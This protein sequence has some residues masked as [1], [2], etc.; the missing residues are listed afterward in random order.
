MP[1]HDSKEFPKHVN[2]SST[3]SFLPSSQL[4]I[5]HMLIEFRI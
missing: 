3:F 1:N 2:F 5:L 4:T